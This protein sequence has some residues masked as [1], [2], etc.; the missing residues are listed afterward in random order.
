MKITLH[1]LAQR[2]VSSVIADPIK[3][4]ININTTHILHIYYLNI[5]QN[6][7]LAFNKQASFSFLLTIF[8]ICL[9]LQMKSLL[10]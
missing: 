2:L 10:Y 5:A 7:H 3:L 1:G 8:S 9:C 4:I 6:I